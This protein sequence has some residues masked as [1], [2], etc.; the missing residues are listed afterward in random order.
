[1]VLSSSCVVTVVGGNGENRR[2]VGVSSGRGWLLER[3]ARQ[4]LLLCPKEFFMS[5][6][7]EE[8]ESSER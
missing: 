5:R 4:G 1:M 3:N 8:M 2:Q 6:D 7:I